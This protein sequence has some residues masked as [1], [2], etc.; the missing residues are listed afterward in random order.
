MHTFNGFDVSLFC[1]I[2][3]FFRNFFFQWE[4]VFGTT[5]IK[6]KKVKSDEVILE[7]TN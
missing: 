6:Q 7:V 5:F 3:L 4:K 1:G 2:D